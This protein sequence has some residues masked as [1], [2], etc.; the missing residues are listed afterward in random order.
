MS[1]ASRV[2]VAQAA[3]VDA[4][5]EIVQVRRCAQVVLHVARDDDD[6]ERA[7][8][9]FLRCVVDRWA[10]AQVDFEVLR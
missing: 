8:G 6:V 4:D 3:V 9:D 10:T 7:F 2:I 5:R 1:H